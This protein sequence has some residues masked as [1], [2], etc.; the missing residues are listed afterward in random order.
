MTYTLAIDLGLVLDLIRFNPHQSTSVTLTSIP[1]TPLVRE[2]NL[3]DRGGPVTGGGSQE[4][5][6]PK[7]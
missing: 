6:T 1:S 5:A 7:D 3:V 2:S 4:K